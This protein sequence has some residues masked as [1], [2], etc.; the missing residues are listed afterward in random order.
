MHVLL[1]VAPP[2]VASFHAA[3]DAANADSSVMQ[4]IVFPSHLLISWC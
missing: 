3:G 4:G 2:S 1:M